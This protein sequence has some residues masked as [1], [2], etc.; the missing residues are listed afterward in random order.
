MDSVTK[1]IQNERSFVNCISINITPNKIAL[2]TIDICISA[3]DSHHKANVKVNY[4]WS[5]WYKKA[6]ERGCT[7]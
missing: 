6:K 2:K 1:I 5:L 3:T 4:F 7:K